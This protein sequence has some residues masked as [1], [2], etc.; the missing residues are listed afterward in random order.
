[1]PI[2]DIVD[3]VYNPSTVWRTLRG[4]EPLLHDGKPFYVTGNSAVLFTVK[5]DGRTKM[6]KCYTRTNPYL[7]E[8]YSNLFHP[9]ELC[10]VAITG[11]II[12]IDCLLYDRVEGSTLN[13]VLC[14]VKSYHEVEALAS[15]FDQMAYRLSA[16]NRTHGDLKPENIV[17]TASNEM[18]P[19]DYDSA[20]VP[21]LAGKPSVE[22]GTTAYQHPQRDFRLFDLH[23]DDYSIAMLSTLLHAATI[24]FSIIEYFQE[25]YEFPLKPRD[26]ASGRCELL[27]NYIE[28]FAC[29][30]DALHY[31][32]ARMLYSQWP[33]LF[34]LKP[35]LSFIHTENLGSDIHDATLEQEGGLWGY[36]NHRGWIIPPIYDS[37]FEPTE[38][39]MVV[40]LGD[41]TH[42]LSIAERRVVHSFAKGITAKPVRN[43]EITIRNSSGMRQTIALSSLFLTPHT[44]LE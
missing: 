20:F 41:Y 15:A 33:R 16:T 36:R 43:G 1:M 7:R 10:I 28:A 30:G 44:H 12:W 2:A 8:I 38:G 23:I 4:I 11:D 27:D 40:T 25:R 24:D 14:R 3:A 42:L 21:S 31:R 9:H 19:I 37:G 26:I 32:M 13:E 22:K 29:R 17:V 6:L 39:F 18:I 5:H 34:N 35:M